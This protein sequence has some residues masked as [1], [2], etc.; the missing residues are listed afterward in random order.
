MSIERIF[1]K[2]VVTVSEDQSIVEVAALMRDH[3]IGDVI[4]VDRAN[5]AMRPIG[6]LTDRDI[7]TGC[8]A[9]NV[10]EIQDCKVQDLMTRNPL[11][12][13]TRTEIY[14][15]LMKMQQRGVGRCPVVDDSGQLVGVLTTNHICE[16]ISRE[17]SALAGISAAHK[18]SVHA[19]RS[20]DAT[21]TKSGTVDTIQSRLQ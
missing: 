19:A 13:E 16:F 12:V 18:E 3:S 10:D 9:E 7:V 11:C 14:E 6:I 15:C 1:R 20:F 5:G 4:V 17:L 21:A 2:N 8:V